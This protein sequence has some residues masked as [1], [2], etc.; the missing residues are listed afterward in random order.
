MERSGFIRYIGEGK[1][2]IEKRRIYRLGSSK[3]IIKILCFM[4]EY[5]VNNDIYKRVGCR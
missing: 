5:I 3:S 2:G 1:N 4:F